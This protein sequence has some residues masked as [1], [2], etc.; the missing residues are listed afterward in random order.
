MGRDGL[1]TI[2]GTALTCKNWRGNL[3]LLSTRKPR[4]RGKNPDGKFWRACK[5]RRLQISRL[6][7]VFNLLRGGLKSCLQ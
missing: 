7:S 3:L 2:L 4:L 6:F 1:K 5:C